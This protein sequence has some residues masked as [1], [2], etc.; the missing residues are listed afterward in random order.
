MLVVSPGDRTYRGYCLEQVAAAY[1]V[2]LL[3]LD[4]AAEQ[5]TL[6]TQDVR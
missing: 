4:A 6:T 3:R 5:I 2:V 1:D